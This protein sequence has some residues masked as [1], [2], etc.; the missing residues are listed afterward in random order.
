MRQP[1][2][3]EPPRPKGPWGHQISLPRW[4]VVAAPAVAVLLIVLL[5]LVAIRPGGGSA[6]PAAA[7]PSPP[8]IST[9][10]PSTGPIPSAAPS[11]NPVTREQQEQYR[12]YVSTVAVD[13]AGLLA[14]MIQLHKC[15]ESRQGCRAA[16]RQASDPVA[17]FESDLDRTAVPACLNSF[18]ADLR[19]ALGFYDRGFATATEGGN[20]R[21]QLKVMQGAILVA[22][23]TWRLGVAARQAR[24]SEC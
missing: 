14:A 13:G 5:A 4:A 11:P 2:D 20:A 10:V 3:S 19:G 17:R 18:D 7:A 22:V 12:A 15:G 9:S 1:G 21:D 6:P 8:A 23:G 24:H 16:V